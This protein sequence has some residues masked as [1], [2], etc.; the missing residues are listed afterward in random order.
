M[1]QWIHSAALHF[2]RAAPQAR[3][4]ACTCIYAAA[5]RGVSHFGKIPEKFISHL[6]ALLKE[7]FF[8]KQSWIDKCYSE[9]NAVRRQNNSRY[10]TCCKR[11]SAFNCH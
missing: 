8:Y 11:R 9:L 5:E 2:R 1:W 4:Q 7:P 3:Y 10:E 6:F